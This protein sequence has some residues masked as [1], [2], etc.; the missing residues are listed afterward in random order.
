MTNRGEQRKPI[1]PQVKIQNTNVIWVRWLKRQ[2]A[3]LW[4]V[5]PEF[6]SGCRSSGDFS[7]LLRVLGST[8]PPI[9]LIPVDSPWDKGDRA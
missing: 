6:D 7:S 2:G 1:V 8:Q 9:K 5:R 3:W 4:A